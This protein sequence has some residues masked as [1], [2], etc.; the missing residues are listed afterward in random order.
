MGLYR[1]NILPPIYTGELPFRYLDL[2]E[3]ASNG[4]EDA[5]DGIYKHEIYWKEYREF[6]NQ[7][8][9]REKNK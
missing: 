9:E 2:V 1:T 8:K 6:L 4:E 5:K 7:M 3:K